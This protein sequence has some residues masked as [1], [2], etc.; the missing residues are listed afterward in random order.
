MADEV[1]RW[2]KVRDNENARTKLFIARCIIHKES[3]Y[4]KSMETSWRPWTTIALVV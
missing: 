3:L 1:V 2:W 4:D